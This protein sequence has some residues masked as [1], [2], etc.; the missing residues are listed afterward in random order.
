MS[1]TGRFMPA[2]WVIASL[3]LVSRVLGLLRESVLGYFFATSELLSAFRIAF[4]APNLAR[5]L[6]GE[7]ALSSAMVPVLTETLQTEGEERSRSFVGRLLLAQGVVLVALVAAIEI[8]IAVWRHIADDPAL[9]L[10]AI[11][12]PYMALI[13]T[14][15]VGGAVL[16]V[17][18]RFAVPAVVPVLLN[19]AIILAAVLGA[20]VLNRSDHA[21][22]R[23]ICFAVL[24][25]GVVQLVVTGAAMHSANFLPVFARPW[26]D[27]R[28]KRVV[29]LMGPMVLG[30]SAVQI[31]SLF[32][33]VIAYMFVSVDGERVGPA[34]LGYAQYLYQLPLGVFGIAIATAIFP[35]LSEYASRKDDAEFATLFFRGLGLSLFIAVPAAV[36]LMFVAHPLVATLYERGAFVR[37]D[38]RRVAG[39]LFF[40][41][42]GMPA[43]FAQHLV[44]RMFYARHDSRTP[45]RTAAATV[46][47][48]VLLNLGLVQVLEERGLAL[49]TSLCAYLQTLWL[50][51]RLPGI[52]PTL[53]WRGQGVTFAKT[54]MATA[55]M[56]VVLTVVFL[57]PLSQPT[58]GLGQLALLG[59]AVG[60]GI[61]S[62]ALAAAALKMDELW[63]LLRRERGTKG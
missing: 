35:A 49:A 47:V 9:E 38:T 5:R 2:A 15:A 28:V 24:V 17:R 52:A 11:L 25:A 1:Q 33:Y 43:Y 55:A 13:C 22:M 48:N 56:A 12:M 44:V 20:A 34:V 60:A 57:S 39:V 62:Y 4:M 54:A 32:D 10:A 53:R 37:E 58:T 26:R 27:A 50:I 29:L 40:Y 8:V 31:N 18:R 42:L 14:V 30:L 16:N 3:T 23:V 45:A 41:S 7:G 63:L 36:G 21:L 6:F 19:L 61:A 59:T 46:L 51:R